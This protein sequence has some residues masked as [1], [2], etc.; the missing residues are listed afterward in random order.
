MRARL[1]DRVAGIAA[2]PPQAAPD[3]LRAQLAPL[4]PRLLG[5]DGAGPRLR[6]LGVTSC[7]SGE[8]VSTVAAHLAVA[9]ATWS[10]QPVLLVDANLERPSAHARFL[11]EPAPGLAEA[12]LEGGASVGPSHPFVQPCNVPNLSVLVAGQTDGRLAQVQASTRLSAV[13]EALEAGFAL[14]VLDL[15]PA[16]AGPFTARLAGL[17]D[18]TILVVEAE[19][20]PW[21]EVEREKGLLVQAGANLLGAVLNKRRQYVP[22]WAQRFI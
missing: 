5:N 9:A 16:S 2:C 17:L 10:E 19:R 8:G 7:I 6:S 4:L 13:L 15:P 11:V 18:G 1:L 12:L 3:E 21:E 20:A 22:R 14:V